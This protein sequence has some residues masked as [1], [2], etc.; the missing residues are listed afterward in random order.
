MITPQHLN[1]AAFWAEEDETICLNCGATGEEVEV[2]AVCG[3]DLIVPVLL[4]KMVMDNVGEE[5]E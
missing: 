1:E 2:C 5:G 3:S 4:A